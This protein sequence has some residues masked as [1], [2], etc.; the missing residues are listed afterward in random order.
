MESK[1][2]FIILGT[3]FCFGMAA[4]FITLVIDFLRP[5]SNQFTMRNPPKPPE[6]ADVKKDYN[7]MSYREIQEIHSKLRKDFIEVDKILKDFDKSIG[8]YS[9]GGRG[10][11]KP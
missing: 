10:N 8:R 5:K 9:D 6:K 1:G 7:N 3:I 4:W 11:Y 2:I